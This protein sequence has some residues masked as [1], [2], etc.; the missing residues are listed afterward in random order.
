MV[1]SRFFMRGRWQDIQENR[2][3]VLQHFTL[4]CGREERFS[5]C[6]ACLPRARTVHI[7]S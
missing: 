7:F 3:A 5:D 1:V 6:Y 2:S 4:I